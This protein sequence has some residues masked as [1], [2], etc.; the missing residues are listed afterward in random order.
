MRFLSN[1]N[2]LCLTAK[3]YT[4]L[5][6]YQIWLKSQSKY[7]IYPG[8]GGDIDFVWARILFIGGSDVLL[9]EKP[10]SP[11]SRSG[12]LNAALEPEC[13]ESESDVIVGVIP[14]SYLEE[15]NTIRQTEDRVRH[16]IHYIHPALPHWIH[17]RPVRVRR[18]HCYH[19]I[20][21]QAGWKLKSGQ[22]IDV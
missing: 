3:N 9:G 10:W 13:G 8:W 11:V 20:N 2:K 18:I 21:V 14:W 12:D 5:K 22:R 16:Y 17:Q 1:E 19:I 7:L 4:S 6:H 15:V